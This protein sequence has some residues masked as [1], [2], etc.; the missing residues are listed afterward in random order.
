MLELNNAEISLWRS[1]SLAVELRENLLRACR[2]FSGAD[3]DDSARLCKRGQ[4]DAR[5]SA[6]T[7]ALENSTRLLNKQRHRRLGWREHDPRARRRIAVTIEFLDEP[8]GDAHDACST[9]DDQRIGARIGL[10]T[11]WRRW[12]DLT[13]RAAHALNR[14][15]RIGVLLVGKQPL[16]QRSNARAIGVLQHKC[17]RIN[18]VERGTLVQW[19]DELVGLIEIGR[20]PHHQQRVRSG[21][22]D[23]LYRQRF[24]GRRIGR[25]T[26]RLRQA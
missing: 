18:R 3:D 13:A 1:E 19:S 20:G 7:S 21:C 25:G 4:F 6:S 16:H 11:H 22:S 15:T 12:R 5:R 24:V 2:S 14:K 23:H 9:R 8:F 26:E 10:N 17:F